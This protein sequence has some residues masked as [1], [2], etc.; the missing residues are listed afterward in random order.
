[1]Y[2]IQQPLIFSLLA[3]DRYTKKTENSLDN[4]LNN[5]NL[6]ILHLTYYYFTY[7]LTIIVCGFYRMLY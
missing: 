4:S 7:A 5:W 3:V 1:M 2:F 6:T